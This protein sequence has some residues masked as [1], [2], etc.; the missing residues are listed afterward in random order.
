[1]GRRRFTFYLSVSACPRL[2]NEELLV[3]ADRVPIGHA[4]E[5]ITRRGVEALLVDRALIQELSGTLSDLLP[6]TSKDTAS[7]LE[8]GRGDIVFLDGLKQKTAQPDGC[9][10][11]AIAHPDF[12]ET[13]SQ[14]LHDDVGD[15][16]TDAFR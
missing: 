11:D 8:L 7:L 10:Q 12:R 2:R 3:E 16:A 15:H 6:Q 13:A 4:G 1:S 9:A 5:K 14:A